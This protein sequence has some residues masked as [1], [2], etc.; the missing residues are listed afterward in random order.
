LTP[1]RLREFKPMAR[2]T[3]RGFC[4][5]EL[6]SGMVITDVTVH[7]S[8]GKPWASPPSKPMIDR[9]GTVMKDGSGKVDTSRSLSSATRK[10][11]TAGPPR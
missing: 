9:S 1:F 6:P 11:A 2:N 3:L 4:T 7:V 8:N 10:R 5:I